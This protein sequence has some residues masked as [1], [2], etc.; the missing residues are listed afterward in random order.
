[1]TLCVNMAEVAII[2]SG[3]SRMGKAMHLI[4][5]LSFFLARWDVALVCKHIPG[6]NNGAADALS[7]NSLPL[8]QQLVPESAE[9]ATSIPE[10]LLQCLVHDAP[11]WT[12]VD[13]VTLFNSSIW[14][15]WLSL[16][17]NSMLAG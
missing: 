1:M 15:V 10:G 12:K 9:D 7:R 2:N 5:C 6:T 11:D 4:R 16:H 8:F 17:T 13:W 14:W 3:R